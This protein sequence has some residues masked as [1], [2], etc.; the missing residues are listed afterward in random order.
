[1]SAKSTPLSR[2]LLEGADAIAKHVW[3]RTAKRKRAYTAIA[4]GLPHFR[5]GNR[6]FA[7]KSV[8]RSWFQDQE[9]KSSL[10]SRALP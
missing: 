8:I 5:I 10:R 6:L 3:G 2:D 4:N 9:Q 1:M 7:R